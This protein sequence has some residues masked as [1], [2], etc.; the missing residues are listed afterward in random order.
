MFLVQLQ[1]QFSPIRCLQFVLSD[2]TEKP[3][4][5][6]SPVL[7]FLVPPPCE[8][9]YQHYFGIKTVLPLWSALVAANYRPQW[10]KFSCTRST[11]SFAG[12]YQGMMWP[13]G[14]SISDVNLY[15]Q[16]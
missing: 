8:R 3:M 14:P 7:T 5:F 2:W 1:E 12:D 9:H 15:L 13:T 16:H 4:A 11:L 6:T 10:D